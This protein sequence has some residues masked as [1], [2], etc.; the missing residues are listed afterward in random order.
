[1]EI[2]SGQ[3]HRGFRQRRSCAVFVVSC[4]CSAPVL[5][6]RSPLAP[7]FPTVGACSLQLG[8]ACRSHRTASGV[9]GWSWRE[10]GVRWEEAVQVAVSLHVDVVALAAAWREARPFGWKGNAGVEVRG[11]E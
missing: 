3:G 5:L 11:I 7:G 10:C 6:P 8:T 4:G 2:Q 1:M 9:F